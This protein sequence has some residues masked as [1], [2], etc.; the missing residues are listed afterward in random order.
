MFNTQEYGLYFTYSCYSLNYSS[1]TRQWIARFHDQSPLTRPLSLLKR[2]ESPF[3]IWDMKVSFRMKKFQNK[4]MTR[5]LNVSSNVNWRFL[6]APAGLWFQRRKIWGWWCLLQSNHLVKISLD[7][8]GD[9]W[10]SRTLNVTTFKW[11]QR[12]VMEICS[13]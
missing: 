12:S 10:T 7:L 2:S 1:F 13:F 6:F 11:T 3:L 8:V 4:K 9:S 5:T